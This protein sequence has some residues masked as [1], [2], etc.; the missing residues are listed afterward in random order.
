MIPK[1]A[2]VNLSPLTPAQEW[3]A[4]FDSFYDRCEGKNL[5]PGSIRF[6]RDKLAAF[7]KWL[8]REGLDAHPLAELRPKHLRDFL[9]FLIS[10]RPSC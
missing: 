10:N 5:S 8:A 3:A 1:T 9:S 2:L 7:S 4:A 6:Y